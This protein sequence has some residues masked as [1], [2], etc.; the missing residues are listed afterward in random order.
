MGD[1]LLIRV[2]VSTYDE[3]DVKK[4]YPLLS[5]MV[6]PVQDKFIPAAQ[7]FGL[8]ELIT[9]LSESLEFAKWSDKTKDLLRPH[10]LELVDRQKKL[11]EYILSWQPKEANALSFEIEENLDRIEKLIKTENVE[12]AKA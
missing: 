2:S 1:I 7:Q 9:T 8:L 4:R 10:V 12:E 5:R 6:W 11:N 3:S